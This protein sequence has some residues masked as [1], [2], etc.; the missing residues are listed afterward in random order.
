M[1]LKEGN[2]T[3]D[4]SIEMAYAIANDTNGN[5]VIDVEEDTFGICLQGETLTHVVYAADIPF[6]AKDN[7]GFPCIALN[8]EKAVTVVEKFKTFFNDK[9]V[10]L[11]SEHVLQTGYSN[12]YGEVFM[13]A[14]QEGRTLFYSNQLLTAI[15]LRDMDMDFGV[16]PLPKYDKTQEYY[17]APVSYWW[18]TFV[19]VP[20]TNTRL[21]MTGNV[22]DSVGYFSQKLVTPAYIEK[23]IQGKSFRDEESSAMLEIILQSRVYEVAAIYNWGNIQTMFRTINLENKEF[24]SMYASVQKAAE[25]ALEKTIEAIKALG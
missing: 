5:G 10:S 14:L 13:P 1:L 7:D 22:M 8:Q 6:T 9:N 19:V 18:A 16:L 2:W 12:P 4:K 15:Q 17:C 11:V 20:V 25:A 24:A 23:S 21:E 3:I